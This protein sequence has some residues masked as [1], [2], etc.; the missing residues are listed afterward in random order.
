V[1]TTPRKNDFY[2]AKLNSFKDNIISTISNQILLSPQTQADNYA[3]TLGVNSIRI[4]V[5]QK[6][7]LDL[8]NYI[9]EDA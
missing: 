2:Y 9:Y 4:P 5:Y 1:I 7:E 6:K 3:P 8:T